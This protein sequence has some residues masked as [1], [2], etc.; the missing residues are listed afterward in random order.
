L[1]PVCGAN[2]SEHIFGFVPAGLGLSRLPPSAPRF[3]LVFLCSRDR[4]VHGSLLP[5]ALDCCRPCL[6][7][8]SVPSRALNPRSAGIRRRGSVS[9]SK[10]LF[11]FCRHGSSAE[12]VRDSAPAASVVIFL[13]RALA[14]ELVGAFAPKCFS[15]SEQVHHSREQHKQS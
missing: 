5:R 1:Y 7:V 10:L 2:R 8:G 9:V 4:S 11:C 13:S 12:R 14:S 15:R 6:A 3:L